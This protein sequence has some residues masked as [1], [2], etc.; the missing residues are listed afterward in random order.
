MKN[1]EIKELFQK[2]KIEVIDTKKATNSYSSNVYIVNGKD[3]KYILKINDTK[4]KRYH[5]KNYYNYLS[6]YVKT[7][8]VLYSGSYKKYQYNI[9]TFLEGRNIFDEECNILSK[10][11][12]Y[13]IG[14]LLANIHNC[15][16]LSM[17]NLW[18]EYLKEYLE[19]SKKKL[20]ELF[21]EEDN[22][23][24]TT[25]L[26]KFISQKIENHYQDC[27]LHMDYRVGNIM[28]FKNYQVGVID[29]ESMRNGDYVFDFVKM[30]RIF[31]KEN[32][33]ILMDGYQTIRKIDSDFLE[34]LDFY[35]FFD[36]YT[37]LLWCYRNHQESGNFYKL[38]YSIVMKY[39]EDLKN[40]SWI[41]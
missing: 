19:S 4:E 17:K 23:L 27:L 16:P 30:N 29:L 14:K 5:E 12:K 38:N 6:Q 31:T 35:S 20:K 22:N 36:S 28:I 41:I 13:D 7:A 40:G 39:L 37:S 18:I 25:F 26:E 32:F 21:G 3:K 1:S 2:Y 10:E 9:I 15:F 11:E 34:K 33:S 24:I 8:K